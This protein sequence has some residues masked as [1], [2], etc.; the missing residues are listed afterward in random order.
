VG[1][2]YEQGTWRSENVVIAAGRARVP[3]R[4]TWPG[5]DQYRGDVLHSSEYRNGDPWKGRPVIVV[6]FGNSA[7]EQALDLVERGAE[8]HLAVRSPVNV[9]PRDIFGMVPVL[10]LGS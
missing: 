8:V 10:P 5:M 1:N 6:G 7:C 3:V 9:L 4:P 2:D